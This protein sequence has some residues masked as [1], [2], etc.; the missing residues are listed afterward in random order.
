MRLSGVHSSGWKARVR[1]G[2]AALVLTAFTTACVEGQVLSFAP[3]S[4]T[5]TPTPT[6]TPTPTPTETP[7]PTETPAPE[8]TA[9][10][11][12]AV[13]P[14]PVPAPT[15]AAAPTPTPAAVTEVV[16]GPTPTPA[17]PPPSP[18][19]TPFVPPTPTP[20]PP[21][22][23]T[24]TPSPTRTPVPVF[25][26]TVS[27]ASGGGSVTVSPEPNSLDGGYLT[28]TSVTLSSVPNAGFELVGWTGACVGKSAQCQVTM[29]ADKGVS[30]TFIAS[31]SLKANG[32][33][34]TGDS[35]S[36]E[37][38][39]VHVSPAPD[40][41]TG[42]YRLGATVA[43]TVEPRAGYAPLAWGGACSGASA[44]AVCTL[45]M[46]GDKDAEVTFA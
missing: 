2:L 19:P 15:P 7:E 5:F 23:A 35:V 26:L 3:V 40:P 42:R 34:A 38:G 43:L 9:T 44:G 29:N 4:E 12:A 39:V 1:A 13:T 6:R 28:G 41:V 36:V 45:T 46:D 8:P 31:P 16:S 30:V 10:Q 25:K 22:T 33:A 18:T 32:S 21:P 20:T 11:V 17:P 27:V 24:P 14:A 37:N